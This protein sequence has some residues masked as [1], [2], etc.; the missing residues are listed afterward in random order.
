MRHAKGYAQYARSY[1]ERYHKIEPVIIEGVL[2][3]AVCTYPLHCPTKQTL[4]QVKEKLS[5]NCS[6]KNGIFTYRVG[7]FYRNGRTEE[8]FVKKVMDVFPE[9]TIESSGS[10]DKPF[11]GGA[12]LANSSHWFVKFSF[13][14]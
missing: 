2:S 8:E 9:A 11:R 7:F 6:Y 3:C 1:G 13:K 14:G 12:S 5:E 10:V 4:K